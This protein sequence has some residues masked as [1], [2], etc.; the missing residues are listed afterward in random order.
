MNNIITKTAVGVGYNFIVANSEDL[1]GIKLHSTNT[2]I[3]Y[4]GETYFVYKGETFEDS[5]KIDA[6]MDSGKYTEHRISN[7]DVNKL[8][9]F[10]VTIIRFGCVNIK[11]KSKEQA[12]AIAN[13]LPTDSIAWNDDWQVSNIYEE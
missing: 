2:M 13:S 12:I 6:L 9:S 8:K 7:Y 5:R 3:S 1:R 10:D 4:K 11:A